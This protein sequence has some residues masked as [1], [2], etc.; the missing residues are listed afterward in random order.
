MK[1]EASFKVCLLKP[2][3]SLKP[4]YKFISAALKSREE[5][6]PLR[7]LCLT[8]TPK[9]S[10]RIHD[11]RE[12]LGAEVWNYSIFYKEKILSPIKYTVQAL[13]TFMKLVKSKPDIVIVQNPPIFAA[14]TCL[15]YS[16]IYGV[17]VVIDHHLVWS[18]SGFIRNPVLKAFIRVV[19]EFCVKR[20][21]L[22][23]TYSDDWE[24][25]LTRMGASKTLTIY[26][27]VDKD[28]MEDADLS[29]RGRFPKDKKLI[30]MPCG[31]GHPLERPDILIEASKERDDLIVVVTGNPKHLRNHIRK[32]RKMGASNVVFPGFLPDEQYR[33]LIA[34]CNFVVNVSDEPYGIPHTITEGLAVSKPVIVSG[35]PSVK[36]LLGENY[37]LIIPQNNVESV[38][39]V[40]SKA[41]KEEHEFVKLASNLYEQLKERREKQVKTLL[42]LLH[43]E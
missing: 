27:F 15:I 37:P 6:S 30:V 4:K 40:L 22:N 16:Q 2:N 13:M 33:G 26:D 10:R 1:V 24:N 17:R 25:E 34:T 14:L 29:V 39:K 21:Y 11:I 38:R 36:K 20:A 9:G 12:L 32:A 35:N 3:S 28:W 31:T 5:V 18:M 43:E 19:E 23:M 41:V 42:K 7:M 8:W